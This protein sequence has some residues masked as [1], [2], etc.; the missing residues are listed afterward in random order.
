MVRK[1]VSMNL[2]YSQHPEE[3][4]AKTQRHPPNAVVATVAATLST[5]VYGKKTVTG[6]S[7]KGRDKQT[8]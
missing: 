6:P 1:R 4:G 3:R 7:E 5:V 8:T 2:S